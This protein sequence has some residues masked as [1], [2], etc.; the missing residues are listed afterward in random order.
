MKTARFGNTNV[1]DSLPNE[2]RWGHGIHAYRIV[3]GIRTLRAGVAATAKTWTLR[4]IATVPS[5][6]ESEIL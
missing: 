1:N 6:N 4:T 3:R 5:L 2:S